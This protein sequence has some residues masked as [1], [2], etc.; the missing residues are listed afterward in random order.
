MRR[1]LL[2]AALLLVLATP[3]NA[4]AA[5]DFKPCATPKGVQCAT[6]DVPIDR[7]G[8][9]P[10][11]FALL[12]HRVPAPQPTGKPPLIYLTGGPGQSNTAVTRRAV[13]RY[14]A[15][16][17]HRDLITFAQRGTGPTEIHCPALEAGADPS[18]AVPACG[19]QL[20]PARNFYTSRDA[21]DDIDAI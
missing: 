1:V 12:V 21:A 4:S 2:G 10:G 15:A 14:G 7:S 9:V 19:D 5:L 3:S 20:G 13:V 17:Q 6:I 18:S 8:N 16:L 11:N